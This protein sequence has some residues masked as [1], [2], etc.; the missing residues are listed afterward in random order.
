MATDDEPHHAGGARIDE[1][2]Q[3]FGAHGRE[4]GKPF[5]ARIDVDDSI[6][7]DDLGRTDQVGQ[8]D[9]VRRADR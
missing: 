6:E 5:P 1:A 9:E 3:P 4:Y 2:E 7:G 8:V